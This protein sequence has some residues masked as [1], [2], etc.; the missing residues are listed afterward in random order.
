MMKRNIRGVIFDQDGLMFDTERISAESWRLAG[1]ETGVV[2]KEEFLCTIRGMNRAD[3]AAR[4]HEV[5][6]DKIDFEALRDRKNQ[7]FRQILKERG[8]PVKPGLRELL[9]YL[10]AH[11]YKMILATASTKEYSMGNLKETGIDSYFSRIVS[12]DM[13]AHS[14]PDPEVFLRAAEALEEEPRH[15]MVLEDSLNGVEAGL[16]GGF[17]TVMVPDL[18]QPDEAL[19]S[20][21]AAVCGSLREVIPVLE[22]LNEN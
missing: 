15:C 16:K 20:R 14:K 12:G 17:V 11:D 10:K 5:F 9:A 4:F 21:V 19:R 6:E 3:A 8:V 18:T 2:L 22:R 7:Y 13:V 1:E